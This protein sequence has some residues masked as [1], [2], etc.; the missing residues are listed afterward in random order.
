MIKKVHIIKVNNPAGWTPN[1]HHA[2]EEED[3]ARLM[4]E[5]GT[6]Q[7]A[8]SW[9]ILCGFT[10]EIHRERNRKPT[11]QHGQFRQQ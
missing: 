11:D 9:A 3:T 7:E 2:V 5:C 1:S 6:Q 8:I 4:F 10:Y